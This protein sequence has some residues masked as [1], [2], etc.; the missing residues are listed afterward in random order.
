MG[1]AAGKGWA[2]GAVGVGIEDHVGVHSQSV[3]RTPICT[4]PFCVLMFQR[5]GFY[6]QIFFLKLLLR[7]LIRICFLILEPCVRLSQGFFSL[8]VAFQ[9]LIASS[10]VP[11]RVRLRF[12]SRVPRAP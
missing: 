12:A 2:E 1:K 10:Q 4:F 11:H 9:Q 8:A 5:P 7:R 6:S 3:P